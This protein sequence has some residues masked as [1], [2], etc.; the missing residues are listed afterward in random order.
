M[1]EHR[2]DYYFLSAWCELRRVTRA[3]F[4]DRIMRLLDGFDAVD[5]RIGRLHEIGDSLSCPIG[6]PIGR[7]RSSIDRLVR[8]G[9][10]FPEL[11][12]DFYVTSYD[13]AISIHASDGC[14]SRYIANANHLILFFYPILRPN[15]LSMI[16]ADLFAQFLTLVVDC[17]APTWAGVTTGKHRDMLGVMGGVPFMSWLLFVQRPI[18]DFPK[19]PPGVELQIVK[20]KG[21]LVILTKDRFSV[22]N[23]AHVACAADVQERLKVAG[24]LK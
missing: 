16:S 20:D 21:T 22:D 19:L 5:T 17:F 18:R 6:M 7:D 2:K 4:V 11:P 23:P 3:D 1:I 15:L 9:S 8:Q 14:T 10:M 13:E 12:F 24:I